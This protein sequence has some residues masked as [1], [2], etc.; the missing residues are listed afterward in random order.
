[1]A[2]L[3]DGKPATT[4]D[5]MD[6]GA[7]TIVVQYVKVGTSAFLERGSRPPFAATVGSGG[8]V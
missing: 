3:D 1:L 8:A 6:L 4:A 7:R 5:G 2:G